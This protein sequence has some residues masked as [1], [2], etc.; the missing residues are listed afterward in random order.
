MAY[1]DFQQI[2]QDLNAKME[3]SI[4]VFKGELA[5]LRTGRASVSLLDGIEVM[6]YDILTPLNQLASLSTPDARTISVSVWDRSLTSAVEKAI[7]EAGLGLN[8]ASDGTLIRVP[9]PALTEE[10]RKELAKVA[11]SYGEQAKQAVR[12]LRHEGMEAVKQ[13]EKAEDD[14]KRAEDEIQKLTDRY[15]SLIEEHLKA[16]QADIMTI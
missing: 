2:K 10:R 9:L 6:A 4:E 11:A 15:T 12:H 8:P 13:V 3:K 14:R 7:R 5:G 1:E 16:K